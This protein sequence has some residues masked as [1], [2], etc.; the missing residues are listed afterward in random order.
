MG[1]KRLLILLLSMIMFFGVLSPEAWASVSLF[2]SVTEEMT[3]PSFWTK[4]DEN[5]DMTLASLE[6]LRALN[7]QIVDTPEC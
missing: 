4:G 3:S 7:Q 1:R 6:Q 2:P 5:A